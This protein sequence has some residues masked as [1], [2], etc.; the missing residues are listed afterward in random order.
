M[1]WSNEPK[2]ANTREEYGIMCKTR[3]ILEFFFLVGEFSAEFLPY[4]PAE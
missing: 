1:L 4:F 2:L 3:K